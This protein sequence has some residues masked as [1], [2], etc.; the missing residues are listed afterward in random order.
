MRD[1]MVIDP[2]W[3]VELAPTFYAKADPNRISKKKRQE[4]IEPLHNPFEPEGYWR[5]SK[6]KG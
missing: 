1:V 4:K 3:L 5:L 2:R 6:R